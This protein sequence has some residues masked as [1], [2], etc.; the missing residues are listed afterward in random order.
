MDDGYCGFWAHGFH[1][2]EY[3]GNRGVTLFYFTYNLI[4]LTP[5][6]ALY[7]LDHHHDCFECFGRIPENYSIL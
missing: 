3:F 2:I 1:Q 6:L 7:F 4:E 5:F